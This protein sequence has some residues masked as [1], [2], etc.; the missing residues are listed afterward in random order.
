MLVA[1]WPTSDLRTKLLC[2]PPRPRT[3]VGLGVRGLRVS[4]IEESFGVGGFGI[5]SE[6][7]LMIVYDLPS[8]LSLLYEVVGL[9][10]ASLASFNGI[11]EINVEA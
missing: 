9:L 7:E 2:G 5:I 10:I 11:S 3:F 6:L 4:M 1:S 8:R